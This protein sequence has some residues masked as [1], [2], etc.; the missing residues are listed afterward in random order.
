MSAP[1]EQEGWHERRDS[2]GNLKHWAVWIQV[3]C[4]GPT[5]S[6]RSHLCLRAATSDFGLT[7]IRSAR[8]EPGE[9]NRVAVITC[10]RGERSSRL[11]EDD[12]EQ[13][14]ATS[15]FVRALRGLWEF[16]YSGDILELAV[17]SCV[18]VQAAVGAAIELVINGA[19]SASLRTRRAIAKNTDLVVYGGD[20]QVLTGTSF[21]DCPLGAKSYVMRAWGETIDAAPLRALLSLAT[22]NGEGVYTADELGAFP[23]WAAG[24]ILQ[25]ARRPNCVARAV[26]ANKELGST[27][28]IVTTSRDVPRGSTLH[29]KYGNNE[30]VFGPWQPP[31]LLPQPRRPMGRRSD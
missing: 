27:L 22:G 6:C 16:G 4:L 12:A 25:H 28:I 21:R 3:D 8:F 15:R 5:A 30:S 18:D 17:R 23:L 26:T 1:N 9:R 19:G 13:R 11:D 14:G 10:G 31:N 2:S 20:V 7:R 29:I 24:G